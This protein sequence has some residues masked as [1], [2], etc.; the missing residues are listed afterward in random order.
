MK[1]TSAVLI[2]LSIANV[3]RA[4][5][6]VQHGDVMRM[7]QSVANPMVLAVVAGV[8]AAVFLALLIVL[9]RKITISRWLIP[10]TLLV[11]AVWIA[12]QPAPSLPLTVW[13]GVLILLVGWRLRS[14][15]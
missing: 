13:H 7:Y 9:W 5:G 8:W 4:W 2:V 15:F 3:W 14:K 1:T 10:I 6:F 11:Y 12:V